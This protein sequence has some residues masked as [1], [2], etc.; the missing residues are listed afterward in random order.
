[1]VDEGAV[2]VFDAEGLS[3]RWIVAPALAPPQVAGAFYSGDVFFIRMATSCAEVI[4]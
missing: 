1:M 4:F 2:P 3:S